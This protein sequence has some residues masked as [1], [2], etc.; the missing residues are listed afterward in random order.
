[1]K[2][3][4]L[5]SLGL[6][7]VMA[8]AVTACGSTSSSSSS[9]DTP[10][11]GSSENPTSGTQTGET[12]IINIGTWYLQYYDSSADS[13]ES[14]PSFTGDEAAY[15][16]FDNVAKLEKKYNC[17]FY[18]KNLTYEG[19]IDSI[20]TS[21]L[22]GTP[23]CDI[24]LV[25]AGMGIPAA[26]NG[27]VTDL[28]EVLPTDSDIFNDKVVMDYL[29]LGDGK[30]H[31]FFPV[32]AETAV[33]ATYPLAF[34]KEMLQNAG[35]E[36]PRDLWE[37]GEWTW[38]KFLEY[39]KVLT[40]DTDGDGV[41]D[42]Y[43]YCGFSKETLQ[44]LMFGNGTTLTAVKDGKMV[45]NLT[46]SEVGEVLE[47]IQKLYIEEKVCYPY[48]SAE[49]AE[50]WNTMR[51]DAHTTNKVAFFPMAAWIADSTGDY[52]AGS[53]TPLPFETCYVPWPVGP[54]GDK[55]TNAG[56]NL[57]S[58]AFYIIPKGVEDPATVYN[59]IYDY[60]NWYD[61]DVTVRDNPETLQWWYSSTARSEEEQ[62][63]NFD[64]MYYCGTH[65]VIDPWDSVNVEMDL[66]SLITGAITP[67]ELQ[68]TYKLQYQDAL[69][70]IFNAK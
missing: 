43:G 60:F 55:E 5:L 23:D 59:F 45:E 32:K 62:N 14:D 7:A 25:E 27:L 13:V 28:K 51:L 46:S 70:T 44:G 22:A 30:A 67:S 36:D 63:N 33:E 15:L 34:N 17:K 49:G 29:D 19:V 26:V 68:E 20:N 2:F 48:D 69:D 24:Y 37:K 11:S 65:G 61:G 12:R 8:L 38:A 39:C 57:M 66:T 53:E 54:S 47:F 21:I 35:L 31:L 42:Q 52:K 58:G 56:K 64:V 1:M 50:P 10:T 40:K 16:K 3:R 41:D 9:S 18:W 4:K 6:A